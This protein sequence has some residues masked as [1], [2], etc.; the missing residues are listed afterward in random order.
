MNYVAERLERGA[1]RGGPQ[2]PRLLREEREEVRRPAVE[3]ALV[4]G[5]APDGQDG[6]VPRPPGVRAFLG[7]LGAPRCLLARLSWTGHPADSENR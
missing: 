3:A 7:A 2:V 1:R 6:R 4:A 5:P